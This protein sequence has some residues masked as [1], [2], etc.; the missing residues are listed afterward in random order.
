MWSGERTNAMWPSRG[1]RL[2]VTPASMRLARGVDVVDL[3]GDVAEVAAARVR[4]GVPVVR[5]L[6]LRVLLAFGREEHEREAAGLVVHAP[7]CFR[8]SLPQKK[9]ATCRGR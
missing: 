9:R 8:P 1:G 5:E 4:L 7:D 2:I 6:D 3:V